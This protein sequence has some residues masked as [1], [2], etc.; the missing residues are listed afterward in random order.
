MGNLSGTTRSLANLMMQVYPCGSFTGV[1]TLSDKRAP[2]PSVPDLQRQGQAGDK[3]VRM[4]IS[5]AH[6]RRT[7]HAI[8]DQEFAACS[9]ADLSEM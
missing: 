5:L 9:D 1:M 7:P 6:R 3:L 8:R 2:A 4:G